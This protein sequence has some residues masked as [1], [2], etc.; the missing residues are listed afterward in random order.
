MGVWWAAVTMTTVGYGDATPKT[1]TGRALALVWMFVGVVAVAI[2]TATV[3]SILTVGSLQST[4]L[5][6]ADIEHLRL[7]AVHGGAGDLFLT[8]RHLSFTPFETYEDALGA[9]AERKL[10]AVVANR[11][12]LRYLVRRDWQGVLRVSPLVLEPVMYA[13]G[14]QSGSPWREPIDRTL[15]GIIEQR[16]WESIEHLYLGNS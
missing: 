15:L 4:V 9:L 14:L 12:G 7:G 2:L 11:T 8:E 16:R 5:R 6:A 3:T 10:D 1:A 13:F